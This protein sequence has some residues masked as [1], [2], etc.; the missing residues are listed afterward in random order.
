MPSEEDDATCID[1]IFSEVA[2]GNAL[3]HDGQYPKARRVFD[4][5]VAMGERTMVTAG[6]RG[7]GSAFLLCMI[8]NRR[9]AAAGKVGD[10]ETVLKDADRMLQL[11]VALLCNVISRSRGSTGYCS[12]GCGGASW[13][14][15]LPTA[16]VTPNWSPAS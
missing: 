4:S 7:P 6:S 3:Y 13:C 15:P 16:F 14:T 5:V 1:E 11:G 2:K 8:Y 10:H 9:A 12:L